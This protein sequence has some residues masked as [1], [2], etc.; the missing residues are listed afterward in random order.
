MVL[1]HNREAWNRQVEFGNEW[2]I[3]V[4]PEQVAEART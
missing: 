3:P 4:S 2:T 1:L